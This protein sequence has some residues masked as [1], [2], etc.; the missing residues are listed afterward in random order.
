MP[1]PKGQRPPPGMGGDLMQK[2]AKMQE[3][4]MQAQGQLAEERITV[5]AGGD[6]VKV[7]IDGQQRLHHIEISKEALAAARGDVALLQDLL[8][9]AVNNAI[10]QSQ[11]LAAER[12]QGLTSEFGLP[13]M[14]M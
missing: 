13:G 12:L 4:M 14:G 9:A 1:K 8:V 5:S 10:E 7:V 6:A 3:E 2:I 11:T